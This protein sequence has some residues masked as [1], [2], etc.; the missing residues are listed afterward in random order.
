V[1]G[2]DR[3][4]WNHDW[5][6]SSCEKETDREWLYYKFRQDVEIGL[7]PCNCWWDQNKNDKSLWQD[8]RQTSSMHASHKVRAYVHGVLQSDDKGQKYWC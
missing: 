3:R 8:S 2:T 4:H 5:V 6:S 7:R 1:I